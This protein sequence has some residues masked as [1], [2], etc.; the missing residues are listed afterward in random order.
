MSC[1]ISKIEQVGADP[2]NIQWKVVRGDTA[3]LKIEFLEN[4][5][6]TYIDTTDWSYAASSY[7]SSGDILDELTV[8]AYSGYAIITAPASLTAFWGIGYKNVV[9]ELPFDLE[10]TITDGADETIWTPVLGT[11]TVLSDITPSGL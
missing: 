1:T 3:T 10:V 6:K 2:I 4:D 5:E 11:I 9:A 8:D 7:D